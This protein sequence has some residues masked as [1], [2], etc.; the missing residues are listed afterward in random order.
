MKII[1]NSG[2]KNIDSFVYTYLPNYIN[3]LFINTLDL[4]RLNSFNKELNLNSYNLINNLLKSLNISKINNTSY[5][6]SINKNIKINGKSA[7]T[8][9]NF[10]T[11][12][13]RSIKG[14]PIVYNIF[15]IIA[16]NIDSIYEQYERGE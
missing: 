2:G 16:N 1:I 11:Y 9:L 7:L 3:K 12:G 5:D 6:I 8:Y 4:N 13:N 14:Y 10:I 15:K